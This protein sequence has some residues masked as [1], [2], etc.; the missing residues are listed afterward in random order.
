MISTELPPSTGGIGTHAF[1]LAKELQDWGW[2]VTVFTEFPRSS[3]E[4][5]EAYHK[6]TRF[7]IVQLFP[8]PSVITLLL[9]VWKIFLQAII[10]R[11]GIIVGTG[12][13]GAWFAVL[14]AKLSFRKSALVGH[15]TEFT[16]IMSERSKKINV[17]VYSNADKMIYV[18]DYTRQIAESV[19][20]FNPHS[21]ILHNGADHHLFYTLP[22]DEVEEFKTQKNING[23]K[24][25]TTVG[26]LYHRKGNEWV[27]RALPKILEAVPN[28]HYYCIGP[29]NIRE[30]LLK[31]A[32]EL[33]VQNHLHITGKLPDEELLLWMNASDIFAMTSVAT[34]DGD[35]EGFG[36]SIIEA[37][38]CHKPAVV[39]SHSGPGEAI[40]EA[41][42]GF[43]VPEKDI[44]AIAEK[45]SLL[46]SDE[47]LRSQMGTEAYQYAMQ[48]LTWEKVIRKYEEVFLQ[49]LNKD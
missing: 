36:I 9:K 19:G 24:I 11:P 10:H 40:I 45:I 37:A 35:V 6:N 43:G 15:G 18:S 39:T 21:L 42:T 48:H 41:K 30:H 49:M 2:E 3:K 23:Q 46:L 8:T 1:E 34:A 25:I 4:E 20:I 17:W 44:N 28:T 47:T 16:A 12:K 29:D 38:M 22:A 26:R 13:H 31:V 27:I 5:N 14:I 7:K 33:G 32:E